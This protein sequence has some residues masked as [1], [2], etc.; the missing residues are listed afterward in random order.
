[1]EAVSKCKM[2]PGDVDA[3]VHQNEQC[4]FP[5]YLGQSHC[6]PLEFSKSLCGELVWIDLG[7]LQG[8]VTQLEGVLRAQCES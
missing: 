1:M 7:V 4:S 8:V 5:C 6:G 3:P 2:L